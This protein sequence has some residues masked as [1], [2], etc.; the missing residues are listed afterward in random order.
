MRNRM[1]RFMMGRYGNDPLNQVITIAALV[2]IFA[3][4]LWAPLYTVALA[5]LVWSLFR[6]FSRNTAK[7]QAE[8]MAFERGKKRV[9]QFFKNGKNLLFGTKTHR[10]FKCP[11]CK[12]LVRVPRGKGKVN[13]HC[14]KC[15]ADFVKKT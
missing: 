5:L 4:F 6:M 3:S 14:P 7:R 11:G 15:Q 8:Y 10:Y 9:V 2:M 1:M 12:Q 13:I